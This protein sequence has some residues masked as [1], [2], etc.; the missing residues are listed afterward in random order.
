[1]TKQL[2]ISNSPIAFC[3]MKDFTLLF[4]LA[5]VFLSCTTPQVSCAIQTLMFTTEEL[6]VDEGE[7]PILNLT[8]EAN[9]T[10]TS[11]E[12]T[13]VNLMFFSATENLAKA[14]DL[15]STQPIEVCI[16]PGPTSGT[17][18][19]MYHQTVDD[20]F[21]EGNEDFAV[22]ISGAGTSIAIPMQG[23]IIVIILDN[24][25]NPIVNL[26]STDFTGR[27]GD[28][29]VSV[30]AQ[31]SAF[32]TNITFPIEVTF[33]FISNASATQ[34]SDY[35][36][37]ADTTAM[38][39]VGSVNGSTACVNLTIIDDDTLDG[40]ETLMVS[41]AIVND[42]GNNVNLGPSTTGTVT[43]EDNEMVTISI[44]P[45]TNLTLMEDGSGSSLNIQVM[46][47][48]GSVIL[49]LSFLTVTLAT[50][51]TI[52]SR[53]DI[54]TDYSVPNPFQV[55]FSAFSVDTISVSGIMAMD[56]VSIEG[57][58]SF[59]VFLQ[60]VP[61]AFMDN[62]VLDTT[63]QTVTI[64]DDDVSLATY[65]LIASVD[66]I[67]GT[68]MTVNFTAFV[69]LDNSATLDTTITIGIE[70]DS[71]DTADY[72]LDED[73]ITFT[74][75]QT[76]EGSIVA[77]TIVDDAILEFNHSF[78]LTLA[79]T[80]DPP[81]VVRNMMSPSEATF[82][83]QDD[84]LEDSMVEFNESTYEFAEGGADDMVCLVI[85]DVDSISDGVSFSVTITLTGDPGTPD[86][87]SLDFGSGLLSRD[88]IFD[89]MSGPLVCESIDII[90]DDN[91]EGTETFSARISA[92]SPSSGTLEITM[93]TAEIT[94][95]DRGDCTVSFSSGIS[96]EF[97]ESD[98]AVLSVQFSGFSGV[99]ANGNL[100]IS[101]MAPF[102]ATPG[103]ISSA[104]IGDIPDI[105]FP[106][107]GSVMNVNSPPIMIVNDDILENT[108]S[109]TITIPDIEDCTLGSPTSI[110]LRVQDDD[111]G[112]FQVGLTLQSMPDYA[113]ENGGVTVVATLSRTDGQRIDLERT[114]IVNLDLINGDAVV[115]DDF[116][117]QPMPTI[118]FGPCMNCVGVAV[119]KNFMISFMN[120]DDLEFDHDFSVNITSIE[121]EGVL[122]TG[123]LPLS[124]N[125]T[126]DE[127][128]SVTITFDQT[129]FTCEEDSTCTVTGSLEGLTGEIQTDF[130][131]LVTA[132][133]NI[134]SLT[135]SSDASLPTPSEIMFS[136]GGSSTFEFDIVINDDIDFE[137]FHSFSISFDSTM[138]SS[139]G[140][141]STAIIVISDRDD[142]VIGLS[143]MGSAEHS[144]GDDL[145]YCVNTMAQGAILRMVMY[146][147][148][149]NGITAVSDDFMTDSTAVSDQVNTQNIINTCFNV[150]AMTDDILEATQSYSIDLTSSN[151]NVDPAAAN[152]TINILDVN[153]GTAT[154][155][156]EAT[157]LTVTEGVNA[158]V[159]PR[160]VIESVPAGGVQGIIEI[161]LT[162]S[163]IAATL[164]EDYNTTSMTVSFGSADHSTLLPADINGTFTSAAEIL[165]VD[166]ELLEDAE[167][168]NVL[169]TMSGVS[170]SSIL[171]TVVILD[172]EEATL[173]FNPIQYNIME[174]SGTLMVCVEILTEAI[175]SQYSISIGL[176]TTDGAKTIIGDDFTTGTG[177][178]VEFPSMS[179]INGTI[180]CVSISIVDD[181]VFE[182]NQ[183]DFTVMIDSAV[184]SASGAAAD[185][186]MCV[187]DCEATVTIED[188]AADSVTVSLNTTGS[189]L[190]AVEGMSLQV[191]VYIS[192]DAAG[193][194]EC[195]IDIALSFSL[196]GDKPASPE[197]FSIM[198]EM[199]VIR[200]GEMEVCTSV[201]L[202]DNEILAETQS[203]SI[204][205]VNASPF[206]NFDSN[207]L[208][209]ISIEDDEEPPTQ[210]AFTSTESIAVEGNVVTICLSVISGEII[211][212]TNINFT[213][214]P[215]EFVTDN[216]PDTGEGGEIVQYP[217][218]NDTLDYDIESDVFAE[219][220][221]GFP[222]VTLTLQ[223][224]AT[225]ACF[226][227]NIVDDEVFDGESE[228]PVEQVTFSYSSSSP[229]V[230]RVNLRHRLI[231]LD[232][233]RNCTA[234]AG[235]GSRLCTNT[236]TLSV[237]CIPPAQV[238]DFNT[239]DCPD[240]SDELN[241]PSPLENVVPETISEET[242]TNVS[243]VVSSFTTLS[244][245]RTFLQTMQ[246]L[247]DVSTVFNSIANFTN[248]TIVP[249]NEMVVTHLGQTLNSLVQWQPSSLE[250]NTTS[251]IVKS[252][253]AVATQ[254]AQQSNLTVEFTDVTIVVELGTTET[255]MRE[256]R[257]EDFTRRA[258]VPASIA[259]PPELFNQ[260][261]ADRPV[262]GV[263]FALY[264]NAALLP[265][266]LL[267]VVRDN[268]T[269]RET[270]VGTPIVAATV[271]PG[272]DFGGDVPLDP[273]VVITL[274]LLPLPENSSTNP[275]TARCVSW[276][277]VSDS[278]ITDGCTTEV[279]NETTFRCSCT[280]L[281]N[282]AVLVDICQRAQDCMND[283]TVD[284]VLSFISYIGIAL[285]CVG[286]VVTIITMI[287]FKKLRERDNSK[288]H[289][290]L[291]IAIL[292]MLIVF[293]VGIE[294]IEVYGGCV[295]VSILIHYFSLV[296]IMW[297]GAEALL[298]FQKL[299]MVFMR[300]TTNFIIILSLV[301][302]LFPLIPVLIP[303]II[304][305]AD[306]T[307]PETDL[308]TTRNVDP[309]TG[310]VTGG[311]CFLKHPGVFFGAFLAPIF[312]VLLFNMVIFIWVIV[313]LLKHT[314]GNMKRSNQKM[315]F[316][317]ALRLLVS[318]SG[319][320][321]LFGLTW[322]FAALTININS[323]NAVRTV[324]QILFTVFASF[325]GFFIFL[326]FVIFNGEAR[327][328]WREFFSCSRYKSEFLHPS[329]YKNTSSTGTGTR[330][331][332]ENTGTTASIGNAFI[333]SNHNTLNLDSEAS[334]L[335]E[336]IDLSKNDDEKQ[337]DTP[338]TSTSQ[339]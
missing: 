59:N 30:C 314:R 242:Y 309:I 44:V 275:S 165:I 230:A 112:D 300:I 142:A 203:F 205:I 46:I 236:E 326:F 225:E 101:L 316:K 7:R 334:P 248:T 273:P 128:A 14:D 61:A 284:Q 261:P 227:V 28:G 191:C 49:G 268:V 304:D 1:M 267:A 55:T 297:M 171:Q 272:I 287:M 120:D 159:S 251:R 233:D 249:I 222:I 126:D 60:S 231:I 185:N 34:G 51:D 41:L 47:S 106:D 250:V 322:L 94:I 280:H 5:A 263:Y 91:F 315:S 209:D 25:D 188:N 114:I 187:N 43:I 283:T 178:T 162:V 67:E 308:I 329:Q 22:L 295:F 130:N 20:E 206:V 207:V 97:T 324:F 118:T 211:P 270:A 132:N 158:T 148:D 151:A 74:P 6:S 99:R 140:T 141:I 152:L 177:L 163:P 306:G 266:N 66:A 183:Q 303:M 78:T 241:C 116:T 18:A 17:V 325:Q 73:S 56:D 302:W 103:G 217:S 57:P 196:S 4:V 318:V 137:S 138:I 277:F 333:H 71:G 156:F 83:I 252:F 3:Q 11:T 221:N 219:D 204:F 19:I 179:P 153:V 88:F 282:F 238:C 134:D 117:H 210:V 121:P 228:S 135:D 260:V 102:L 70:H 15:A 166:D 129:S 244:E 62:V 147:I 77:V 328:S 127:P 150:T 312:A 337:T 320:M 285:S 154:F 12:C 38:F 79:N 54:N 214:F 90:D 36:V 110:N 53:T 157:S 27:E 190:S 226:D 32:L 108:E 253:E 224:E 218:A 247:N 95:T 216:P 321:F 124:L 331:P 215:V 339:V 131:V 16:P 199:V 332:K 133:F 278:W 319:V 240:M 182:G 293:A 42:A 85:R 189:P 167:D 160:L 310:D 301:C 259:L 100:N 323:S 223:P 37:P 64:V 311:I 335:P 327:E 168:M 29:V 169:L 254:F 291:S 237:D 87:G 289:I 144:E 72:V 115:M 202:I 184:Y 89:S 305:V 330:I 192:Q 63:L 257:T 281:T 113:E 290:Q 84:E 292:C 208:L 200:V 313:I 180:D 48:P 146:N 10:I 255:F 288:Y 39:P 176:E 172:N 96:T 80:S 76:T 164:T 258:G 104:D 212:P 170:G 299:V 119:A 174:G 294:R 123:T 307:T 81:G 195:P 58:H 35:M 52:D 201:Q 149:F 8:Y 69:V 68:D 274:G 286:L 161:D 24:D 107:G 125:I 256:G 50:N 229:I 13:G 298:M 317:T 86:A 21:L 235:L 271:G 65:N 246:F 239:A 31:V 232:N 105:S 234:D 198:D 173:R 122:T 194:R 136:A 82:N 33:S 23:T 338:L 197:D 269:V 265:T 92:S 181:D 155:S 213:T 186:V 9:Q 296:S 279:M 111:A 75:G 2:H 336:K 264:E 26:E 276:D 243:E 109:L 40:I 262:I 220:I 139:G 98:G 145:T 93:E 143:V 45:V 193:G 245:N 175:G